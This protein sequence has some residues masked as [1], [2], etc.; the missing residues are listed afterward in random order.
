VTILWR[1]PLLTSEYR[2]RQNSHGRL[3]VGVFGH[4]LSISSFGFER[5]CLSLLGSI[6]QHIVLPREL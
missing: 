4:V 6:L 1:S 5:L 2:L 3:G